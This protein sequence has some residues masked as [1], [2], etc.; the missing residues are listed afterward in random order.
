MTQVWLATAEQVRKS[1]ITGRL[2]EPHVGWN[3]R[4]QYP[5]EHSLGD[6]QTDEKSADELWKFTEK[7]IE[8][9]LVA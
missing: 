3:F 4:F 7:A 6:I 8:K 2:Y 5:K 1:N 9:A